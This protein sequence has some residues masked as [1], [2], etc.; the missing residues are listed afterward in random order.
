MNS[1]DGSS[2]LIKE[3]Y[4]SGNR[5]FNINTAQI[6]N[7]GNV[8]CDPL[9]DSANRTSYVEGV[10]NGTIDPY[11]NYSPDVIGSD[12]NQKGTYDPASGYSFPNITP[13]YDPSETGLLPIPMDKYMDFAQDALDN[14]ENGDIDD[15]QGDLFDNFINP[16]LDQNEPVIPEPDPDYTDP[17]VI[18][19]Q[20]DYTPKTPVSDTDISDSDPYTTPD[21]MERFPFC[22]PNDIL[23]I[24]NKFK[25]G[26]QAPVIDWEFR[27]D[28]IGL[29]HHM[30]IDFQDFNDAASL[31]RT[32]EL[33][34]FVVGLGVATRKLIGV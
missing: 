1:F 10:R 21:L 25:M 34:L 31:L 15:L 29:D 30:V 5:W 3:Y 7:T 16:Y 17:T 14:T 26:R 23:A 4:F 20:P 9:I 8:Y 19:E 24:F 13:Y 28:A 33:I 27:Y 2:H 11:S 22:I 32:L 18:P 12:G 6:N